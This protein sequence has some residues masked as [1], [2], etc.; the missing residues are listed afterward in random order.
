MKRTLSLIAILAFSVSAYAQSIQT[1]YDFGEN[2][3]CATTTVE[4][5]RPD[6]L[7]STFFFIDMNY[8]EGDM[9][10]VTNAYWEIARAFN[11]KKGSSLAAH[12]EYDGGF[13]RVDGGYGLPINSAFLGGL[14]NTWG[15][16]N[17][18]KTFTLQALFKTIQGKNDASFQL[19]AVWNTL[20]CDGKFSFNGFMDFWKEDNEAMT[21]EA[22]EYVWLTEPQLWYNFQN[23]LK[24][25]S[26]GTEIEMSA[27]FSGNKGFMCNPTIAMKYAF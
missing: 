6:K 12:V 3:Q 5:F 24:G 8:N 11:L 13:F 22:T 1:H 2:R 19:T 7:G 15:W 20:W 23:G 9:K 27:N 16:D 17:F 10:G 26:L 18:N 14:E 4:M 21:G 25:F